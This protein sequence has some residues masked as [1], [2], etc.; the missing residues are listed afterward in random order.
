MQLK[1]IKKLKFLKDKLRI[2]RFDS[3]KGFGEVKDEDI[4]PGFTD[5]FFSVNERKLLKISTK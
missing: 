1:Q 4:H 3:F 2:Y 5:Q